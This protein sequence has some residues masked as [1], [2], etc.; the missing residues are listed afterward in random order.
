MGAPRRRSRKR[1]C[2]RSGPRCSG[3]TGWVSTDNFFELGGHSLLATRAIARMRDVFEVE[4][5]LRVRCSRRRRCE[6]LAG[7]SRSEERRSSRRWFSRAGCRCAV[8]CAGAAV[9]P[10]SAWS[11]RQLP[12]TFRPRCGWRVRSTGSAGGSVGRDCARGTRACGHGLIRKAKRGSQMIALPGAFR[13]RWRPDRSSTEEAL[14]LGACARGRGSGALIWRRG[15]LSAHLLGLVRRSRGAGEHAP[16]RLRRLVDRAVVREIGA[17]YA[18][19]RAGR[20]SRWRLCRCSTR[21]MRCGSG[22]AGLQG[23]RALAR[24]VDYWKERLAGAPAQLDLPS[25]RPRPAVASYRGRNG[26]FELAPICSRLSG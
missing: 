20:V 23:R 18:A 19:L 21:T 9:V 25:D 16:H 8:V 17:L 14:R 1:S 11:W 13:W 24:Q 2:A 26:R 7:R 10:G 3:S 22:S 6:E 15:P 5:A 12:T 4:V